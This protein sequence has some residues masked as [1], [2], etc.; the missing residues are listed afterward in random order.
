MFRYNT[1][2]ELMADADY[3]VYAEIENYNYAVES[4]S[5]STSEKVR[6]IDSLYGNIKRGKKYL[7]LKW[8]DM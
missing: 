3:V 1:I 5:V 8:E 7:Y 6:V 4:G 2:Q